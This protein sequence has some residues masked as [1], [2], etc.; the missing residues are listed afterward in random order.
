MNS[1]KRIAIVIAAALT[2]SALVAVPSQAAPS[3]AY[4]AMYDTTNGVQVLNGLATVTLTSDTS[5][6]TTVSISGVGSVVLAQAGANATLSTLQAGTWYQVVTSN[7]GAGTSTF[8]ITSAVAGSTTV[9]A[10]PL[11]S[12]GTPGTAVTKVITWTSTGSLLPSPAYTTVYSAKGTTA[13][14]A[15]TNTV[16]ITSPMTANLLAGNIKIDLRDGNNLA[17]T[18]GTLT[19]FV[20]GPG[21]IGLGT[22]QANATLTGRAVT[23]TAGQYFINVFGDGTPG[24][25]TISVYSGSTFLTTK[26]ITFSGVAASYAATKAGSVLKVGSNADAISVTVKDTAGNLVADG[27][28]V[29]ATSDTSSV[30]TIASS[31]TTLNGIAKFAVQGVSTGSATLTFRNDVTTPTVST[32][33]SVRVGSSTVASVSLS[34]D[35]DLYANGEGVKL[36]LKALDAAGLTVA[37]GTY[38]DL[39][40]ADLVSSTQFGGASLTGSKSPALVDGVITYNLFAPL[41]AGPFTVIGKVA[42]TSTELTARSASSN[43]ANDAVSK[44]IAELVL[45][46]TALQA[47]IAKIMKRLKIK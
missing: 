16:A 9:T 39:L 38:T 11:N 3:I 22:S 13:P 18:N 25:S 46:I 5:T 12:N 14:D 23:G 1:F 20:T 44:Q 10:T 21:F 37:D 27:T 29:N 47:L 6:T 15:T 28:T 8:V 34:F 19:V 42:S 43:I 24:K 2:G 31:A 36:T 4:T 45:K 32:T 30:A 26:S 41:T 17:I 33:T 40:S 7:V 35:K